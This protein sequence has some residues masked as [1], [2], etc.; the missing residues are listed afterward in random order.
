ML[1][2]HSLAVRGPLLHP[3]TANDADRN[4]MLWAYPRGLIDAF[5]PA[6]NDD[7]GV[8]VR[9]ARLRAP[10][11]QVTCHKQ[12]FYSLMF[13]NVWKGSWRMEENLRRW[14]RR[15]D[16]QIEK[17]QTGIRQEFELRWLIK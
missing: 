17:R 5:W 15:W 1:L 8:D 10:P 3:F 7:G 9:P 16:E 12:A 14:I 4:A 11:A 13:T 2:S 6:G